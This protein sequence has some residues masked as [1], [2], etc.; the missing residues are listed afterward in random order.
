MWCGKCRSEVVAEATPDNQRCFCTVCG[1][2]LT[3]RRALTPSPPE[4]PAA[5]PP[6]T[7]P[8]AL[9]SKWSEKP[10]LDPLGPLLPIESTGQKSSLSDP[11]L[12]PTQ[13]P[14]ERSTAGKTFRVDAGNSTLTEAVGRPYVAPRSGPSSGRTR[15]PRTPRPPVSMAESDLPHGYRV[16][17]R[18]PVMRG[19]HFDPRRMIAPTE[20]QTNW[21]AA[22]GQF[23]A[24]IGAATLAV[25]A[26]MVLVGYLGGPSHYAPTGWFTT[27]IGQMLLFLGVVTLV[28]AG[29]EQTTLEVTRRV[30]AL[31]EQLGRLE[32]TTEQALSDADRE[33]E[34]QAEINALRRELASR[35][36]S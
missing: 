7:D 18:Q 28:S 5:R 35:S 13:P 33:A 11:Q 31:G 3:N 22:V 19:P 1:N 12:R 34:L 27:T 24:Y 17:A 26:A 30:D 14:E 20:S 32:Q 15:P 8:Q 25:G 23:L 21:V 10:L 36:G 6:V 9:L 2:E 4:K 29:M 16:D